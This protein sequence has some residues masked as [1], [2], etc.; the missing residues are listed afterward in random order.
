MLHVEFTF[1]LGHYVSLSLND[2]Y[3]NQLQFMCYTNIKL[4]FIALSVL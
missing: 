1:I 3:L 2:F 4:D